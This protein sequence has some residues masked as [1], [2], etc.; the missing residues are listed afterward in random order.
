MR[1]TATHRQV[2]SSRYLAAGGAW[3]VPTLD[4][5]P[6]TAPGPRGAVVVDGSRRVDG[7]TLEGMVSSL[8][9]GL[10][11]AGVRRRDAVAWQLPN[12]IEAWVLFRACWRLGAVAVPIHHQ[13]GSAE[14]AAMVEVV[15]PAVVL[16]RAPFPLHEVAGTLSAVT[17]D[18][19]WRTLL[20]TRPVGAGSA[21]GSDIAVALFTSGSTGEPKAVLHTHRGLSYK[22]LTMAAAHG[23]TTDDAVLMPAP[24]AHISGLLSGVL[25]PMAVGMRTVL[26]ERWDAEQANRL[27][28][29]EQIS[30]MI[31]PPTYFDAMMSATG[32]ST[33]AMASLRIVSC[34]SMSVAPTFVQSVSEAFGATVKRTYGSTEA[35]T[36]TTSA[37]DDPPERARDTDGRVVSQAELRLVDPVTGRV[38]RDGV[39]EL[40]LRGPELFAGYADPEQTRRAMHRGWFATGDLATIDGDG[41]TTIVGRLKD[42]I[43]RGG[44]NIVPAE[45]EHILMAHPAVRQVV[46]VGYPDAR[47][48]ERV[49]AC[50]VAATPFGIEACRSWFAELGIARFKTPE[51]V[52]Q[53]SRIPALSLGKPDRRQLQ[54]QIA[55][56]LPS[57]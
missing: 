24:L 40:H 47:M 42:V 26:M 30:F 48:G 46:V 53:L 11:E 35:P 13:L 18:D 55:S 20:A 45:V 51:R 36:I 22:A 54:R 31:G 33:A 21:R 43:I 12:G 44:E 57:P 29:D 3:D 49:A 39:G 4:Q 14:V 7:R 16:S 52:Y 6:R 10:R 41:W 25:L 9:G 2:A 19:D 28:P 23:L 1:L 34:G 27:V 15:R 38:V 5:L 8:A 32:Q 56:L 50:V 17:G 37:W